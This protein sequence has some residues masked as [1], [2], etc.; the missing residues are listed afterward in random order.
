MRSMSRFLIG[1]QKTA[2]TPAGRRILEESA[3]VIEAARQL[4]NIAVQ[5]GD[6][7][8][9]ELHVVIDGSLP[10]DPVNHAL[11]TFAKKSNTDSD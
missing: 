1:R 4:E 6:G 5:L 8:E 2:L 10:L 7:W 9:P 3:L 11:K